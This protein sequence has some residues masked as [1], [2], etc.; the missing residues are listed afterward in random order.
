[1]F[2]LL[3]NI[4]LMEGNDILSEEDDANGTESKVEELFVDID[5]NEDMEENIDS[6]DNESMELLVKVLVIGCVSW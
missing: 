4:L 5:F 1:M 2:L 6:E 3:L